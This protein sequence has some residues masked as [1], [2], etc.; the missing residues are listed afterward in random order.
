MQRQLELMTGPVIADGDVREEAIVTPI[1]KQGSRNRAENY[2]P[3]S[4]TSLVCK[5]FE[6]IVRDALTYYLE[7]NCLV[8]DSQ[9]GF[10]KGRSLSYQPAT[11]S[12]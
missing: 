2:R 8:K 4:L 3:V 10:R 6:G 9:H 11:I 5:L 1:F 12:W 7:S